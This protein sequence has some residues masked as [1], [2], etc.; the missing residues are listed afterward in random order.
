MPTIAAR[1]E[2][3]GG[4]RRSQPPAKRRRDP[5][6][7]R[8]LVLFGALLM[9]GSGG[10][11]VGG[12]VLIST[13]TS[14]IDQGATLG[15]AAA[16]SGQD[17]LEGALNIVMV[18]LDERTDTNE[19]VRADSIIILHVPA[20]HDQAYLV[21]IPRDLYVQ[22]P[23]VKKLHPVA[24]S[25]KI[26]A[27]YAYG[28]A[29]GGREGGFQVLAETLGKLIPGLAFNGG[30]IVNFGAFQNLVDALGGVDMCLDQAV[31]SHH[32]G[33]N[34]NGELVPL[35]KNR[36]AKPVHYDV[37]CRH[38]E[39]WEALDYARQRYG[40]PNTDY[41]RARHQQQFLK[42]V[43]KR[44]KD[45]GVTKNPVKA[46]QVMGSAGKALTVDTNGVD[47][48]DWAFTMRNVTDNDVVMLKINNGTFATV[49]MPDG[50]EAEGLSKESG[51]L[52]AAVRDDRLAQFVL[53]NPSVVS[54]DATG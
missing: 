15:D 44:A 32:I 22:I 51:D 17:S 33:R 14:G 5:M 46:F 7:A 37:G 42:A 53:Q 49:R 16:G 10:V 29:K 9:M 6:W 43:L 35:Y 11:I 36:N 40:L 1:R 8:L 39:G 28:N 21:S 50:S 48:A 34:K 4:E 26:N 52:L 12:K 30:A 31:D 19:P 24:E 27:A 45:Q 54:T 47:L 13:A 3:R 2:Q 23:A 41:D 18:G 20:T 25:N 38:L